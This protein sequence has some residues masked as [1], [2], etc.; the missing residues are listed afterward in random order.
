MHCWDLLLFELHLRL[1][2]TVS[3]YCKKVT[4]QWHGGRQGLGGAAGGESKAAYKLHLFYKELS[5]L[6]NPCLGQYRQI[7][8]KCK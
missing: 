2:N 3:E 5:H 1:R 7:Y 6:M 4:R 8:G